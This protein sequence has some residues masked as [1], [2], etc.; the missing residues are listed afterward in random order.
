MG[1]QVRPL[2]P[3]NWDDLVKLFGPSGASSGCWC[4]W[5][6]VPGRELSA[7]GNAGNKAALAQAVKAGPRYAK[8]NGASALE[9]YPVDTV[10]RR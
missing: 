2:D 1:Y 8:A 4:M 10:M 3:E 9:G 6:R 7:N 5:W